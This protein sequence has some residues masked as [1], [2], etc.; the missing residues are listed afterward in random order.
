VV[1]EYDIFSMPLWVDKAID[2][3]KNYLSLKIE[4]NIIEQQ[5]K[6][7]QEELRITTQRVNLFEKMKI[8]KCRENIRVINIFLGD[9]QTAAVVCGKI[10]KSKLVKKEE[11]ASL[12]QV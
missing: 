2:E 6:L 12:A 7:L 8:P 9:E 1:A 11:M 5:I 4:K 10:A 3:V